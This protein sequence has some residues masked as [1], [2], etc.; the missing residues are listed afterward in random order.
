MRAKLPIILLTTGLLLM[1][2]AAAAPAQ[3]RLKEMSGSP[4]NPLTPKE[5]PIDFNSEEGDFQVTWPG[6]CNGL[7]TRTPVDEEGAEGSG[8]RERPVIVYCDRNGEK[9]EGCSVTAIFN[10]RD[11]DGAPAGPENVMSRLQAMLHNLGAEVTGQAPLRKEFPDGRLVEGIDVHAAQAGGSGQVWLRGLIADGTIY[12]LAAWDLGGNVWAN[13]DYV[14]FFN[15]FE[16][17]AK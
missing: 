12:I 14:T 13:P 7:R 17:G 10:A 8:D 6:G 4:D 11:K 2:G 15:S 9:G 1:L 16:P 3:E 5:G